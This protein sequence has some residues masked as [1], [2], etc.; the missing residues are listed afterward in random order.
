MLCHMS[1]SGSTGFDF[2]CQ[3]DLQVFDFNFIGRT[4]VV[5]WCSVWFAMCGLFQRCVTRVHVQLCIMCANAA[6]PHG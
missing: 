6:G 4:L 3:C 2:E 5:L 1:Y